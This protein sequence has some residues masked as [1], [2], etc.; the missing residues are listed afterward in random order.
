MGQLFSF[1][2]AKLLIMPLLSVIT[3]KRNSEEN[4]CKGNRFSPD[5]DLGGSLISFANGNPSTS[6]LVRGYVNGVPV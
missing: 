5:L 6:W 2:L 1:T 4:T 3:Y